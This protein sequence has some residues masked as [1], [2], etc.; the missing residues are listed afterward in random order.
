MWFTNSSN[1]LD[2]ADHHRGDGDH[3]TVSGI[4]HPW[5]RGRSRRG[6]V[7]H[8]RRDRLDR[9]DHHRGKVKIYTGA[10]ISHPE[11]I[12]AGPD[13]ALWFT[14]EGNGSIGRITTS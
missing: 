12:A 8:Q 13:G 1:K 6:A 2:R 3:Y 4:R 9:A 7:V 14:N 11:G 10:G 5:D